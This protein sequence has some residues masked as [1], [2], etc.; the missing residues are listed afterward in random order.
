[1]DCHD[2]SDAALTLLSPVFLSA[3]IT[4]TTAEGVVTRTRD[5]WRPTNSSMGGA[6]WGN[7][8]GWILGVEMHTVF[9]RIFFS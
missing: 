2:V 7:M 9:S 3:W 6:G 1:M 8:V 5:W 4:L